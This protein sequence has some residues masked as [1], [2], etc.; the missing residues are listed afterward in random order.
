MAKY[1]KAYHKDRC[2]G[3][4]QSPTSNF[5]R[6]HEFLFMNTIEFFQC[7]N[8][9]HMACDCNLTWAPTQARTM[10]ENKVTQVWRRKQ[11]KYENILIS[12]ANNTCYWTDF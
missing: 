1:C 8:I 10:R 2:Y 5:A 11:I 6:N 12:P 4:H 7:H 3:P 9:G